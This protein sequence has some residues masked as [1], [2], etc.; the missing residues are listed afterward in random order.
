MCP[1]RCDIHMFAEPRRTLIQSRI[2]NLRFGPNI[3]SRHPPY[4]S[5][6]SYFISLSSL[7][8]S[9][10][11]PDQSS[12][13]SRKFSQIAGCTGSGFRARRASHTSRRPAAYGSATAC[14]G[15]AG[16]AAPGVLRT[17]VV[18]PPGQCP[19]PRRLLPC[20]NQV[21]RVAP[22][23]AAGS[24]Q[25]QQQQQ[26]QQQHEQLIAAGGAGLMLGQPG[27]CETEGAGH[28]GGGLR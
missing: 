3:V 28:G 19:R 8:L 22:D 24:R 23:E 21:P 4:I 20:C 12:G 5:Y 15:G 25:Q 17:S 9:L 26:Q 13:R 11:E 2:S 14:C 1:G 7:S 16:H 10:L 18:F 27:W 6:V